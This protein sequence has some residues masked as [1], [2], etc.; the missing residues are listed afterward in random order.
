VP[1]PRSHER[2]YAWLQRVIEGNANF[3]T[4][5]S[6]HGIQRSAIASPSELRVLTRMELRCL[7]DGQ[8]SDRFWRGR[9]EFRFPTREIRAL[10]RAATRIPTPIKTSRR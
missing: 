3:K 9:G 8:D 1:G 10:R 4:R 5:V 6:I 7:A 2:G